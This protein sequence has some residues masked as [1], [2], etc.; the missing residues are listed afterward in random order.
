MAQLDELEARV[1]SHMA[2]R[3]IGIKLAARELELPLSTVKAARQ[4]AQT[5]LGQVAAI[6]AA[7]RMCDYRQPAIIAHATSSAR[8]GQVRAAE[9]HIFACTRCRRSYVQLVREMRRRKFQR[10][11]TA[12]FLPP[13]ALLAASRSASIFHRVAAFASTHI[14]GDGIPSGVGPR[15][16]A[17]ALLGS[18]ASAAKA[19]GVLA[20]ATLVIVG[21]TTVHD[22]EQPP[23]PHYSRRHYVPASRSPK[24]A[25]TR[26]PRS[27]LLSASHVH[28]PPERNTRYTQQ[29]LR[30]GNFSYLGGDPSTTRK[31]EPSPR[32][33]SEPPAP[34]AASLGYLGGNRGPSTA[35]STT[36]QATAKTQSTEGGQFSP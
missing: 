19:A 17:L 36:A 3:G 15:E 35:T 28:V 10:G 18:G 6:A 31:G 9:A 7:G 27:L 30:A 4:S 24:R 29:T 16:R 20:G 32:I 33:T 34:R 21:A 13:S 23:P 1:T 5:K 11:A 25:I 22:F 2:I 8:P 26:A 14:P 12:A